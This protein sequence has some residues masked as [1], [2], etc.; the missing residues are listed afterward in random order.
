MAD[1]QKPNGVR[2][3]PP[4]WELLAEDFHAQNPGTELDAKHW[5]AIRAAAAADRVMRSGLSAALTVAAT[6]SVWPRR[7]FA[8]DLRRLELHEALARKADPVAAFPRPD[9]HVRVEAFPLR[10][11]IPG[12]RLL[13]RSTFQ[14]RHPELADSYG[15][16]QRNVHAC[17]QHWFHPGG[18]RPTLIMIHGYWL[19]SH[20]VNARWF[21]LRWFYK[22]GY[23]ILL[24]TM[25]FHGPRCERWD[26]WSGFRLFSH[27]WTHTN[28]AISQAVHDLR[29]FIDYLEGRGVPRVGLSGL[30]LG[31]YVAALMAG[32]DDRL[33]FCIPNAPPVSPVDLGLEWIPSS[34]GVRA[35]LKR[36]GLS[37]P[38]MRGLL[39]VHNP[40]TYAPRIGTDRIL[41]IGGAADRFV[42]PKHI[43]LLHR[44]WPGSNL[45]WF[46]GN[47]VIHWHQGEYLRKMKRF[48]DRCLA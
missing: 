28:E 46:P 36:H 24:Y 40:L 10:M 32:I 30:S 29:I 2:A 45:H 11:E 16:L 21:A 13:F 3:L 19:D 20:W 31:G 33:A 7:R 47:H 9:S 41:L 37:V 26:P 35:F 1:F 4:W 5:L 27:G 39:A 23:D 42:P 44:H 6:P 18:P 34:A 38:Q 43:Q 15:R 48:M 17:A 12:Q 25:P 14:P 22:H 8:Q